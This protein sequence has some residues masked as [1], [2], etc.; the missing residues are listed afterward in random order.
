MWLS[1]AG[2]GGR[3]PQTGRMTRATRSTDNRS[4]AARTAKR[5][6]SIKGFGLV[7]QSLNRRSRSVTARYP[8]LDVVQPGAVL[9]LRALNGRDQIGERA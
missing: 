9:Q 5:M 4:V 3:V 7:I 1:A 6:A 8:P 2:Q